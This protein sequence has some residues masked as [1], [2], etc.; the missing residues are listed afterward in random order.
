MGRPSSLE[1]SISRE[2]Q[3]GAHHEER[4]YVAQG[5]HGTGSE[6]RVEIKERVRRVPLKGRWEKGEADSHH[7]TGKAVTHEGLENN[8]HGKGV[9]RKT[10]QEGDLQAE[11]GPGQGLRRRGGYADPE[12]R[13]RVEPGQRL[14]Q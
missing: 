8:T 11:E 5:G 4:G 6:G 12:Q 1:V 10:T 2:G 14:N 9:R 13:I 7:S 3:K